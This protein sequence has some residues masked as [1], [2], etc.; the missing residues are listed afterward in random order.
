MFSYSKYSWVF[1]ATD[2][3]S[4]ADWIDANVDYPKSNC[5]FY[6]AALALLY[7]LKLVRGRYEYQNKGDSAH[8]WTEDKDGT[9][10]D[11]TAHQYK[12]GGEYSEGY[13]VEPLNNMA[14]IVRHKMFRRLN[15]E[16]RKKIIS[17]VQKI[18]FPE[19]EEDSIKEQLDSRGYCYTTRVKDERGKYLRGNI[20]I[21]PW[22]DV[23]KIDEVKLYGALWEHPFLQDLTEEQ[24]KQID[25]HRYEVIKFSRFSK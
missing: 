9:R 11:P 7:D 12:K 4:I 20:Y 2:A 18:S 10:Y 1:K 13:E 25:G 17:K 14:E 19:K 6:A 24:K 15:K 3:R 8:F 21:A 16:D 22:G 23:L 5:F